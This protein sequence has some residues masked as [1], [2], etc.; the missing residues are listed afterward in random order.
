MPDTSM[1]PSAFT[2]AP[3]TAST[4][5]AFLR[6]AASTPSSA[7]FSRSS[8]TLSLARSSRD[9]L[10][11]TS[12]GP[13]LLSCGRRWRRLLL[14]CLPPEAFW[15]WLFCFWR[16]PWF[17]P[18]PPLLPLEFWPGRL[19]VPE[20]CCGA[21]WPPALT[22]LRGVLAVRGAGDAASACGSAALSAGA[23][24]AA[25][26]FTLV[27]RRRVGLAAGAGASGATVADSFSLMRS[28]LSPSP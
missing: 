22:D 23:F 28:A 11:C 16:L 9:T 7:A 19:A 4:S 26:A 27:E 12:R 17:W 3:N 13:R 15:R 10:G 18:W 1:K 5:S 25:P 21:A 14:F 2:L 20:P 8:A 6:P 24:A